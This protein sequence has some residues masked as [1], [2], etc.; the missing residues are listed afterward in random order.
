MLLAVGLL[1]AGVGTALFLRNS[2]IDGVDTQ[3]DSLARTDAASPLL[4]LSSDEGRL[5]AEPIDNAPS[6]DYFVAVYEPDEGQLLETAGGRGGPAPAFPEIYPLDHAL[7]QELQIKTIPSED[8]TTEFRATVTVQ[9]LG[10]TGVFYTQMVAVPLATVNRTIASYI[11]IYSILAILILV[12]GAVAT[13]Y[14]VTLTFRSLG[15]V[16]STA[17]AIAAGDF[18]LRMTDIEP[19][20]TE[21]GRLKTAINAMLDRVDAALS[22]RDATVRQMRRFIG[23][24]S[25]EL[26]TPLVTVRGYA[27]LYRMGAVRGEEDISQ[28][29]DRIEKEAIRMGLLVED[30]LALARLDERRDVVIGP[31]DLRPVARDAALDVRAAAPLRPVAVLDSTL[32]EPPLPPEGEASVSPDA[33]RRTTGAS[34]ISRAGA[35]LSLLRRR[36]KP[37][38]AAGSARDV[39]SPLLPEP[40]EPPTR[41]VLAPV[42]LGDENRIR[43]VVTNLL[44]NARRYSSEDSPIE[45]RVGVDARD[46][47]GWIEV[48]DHGEGVP[49]QIKDKIFQRFWRADTSRTRETGGSGL[50]L[51]IVASIVE[52]L[53]G[54]VGVVDT[55]GGGATFRVA[56]PL[57]DVRDAAEHLEIPTQPLPRLADATE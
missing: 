34:T 22:Q 40:E 29:M 30:L 3:V 2:L 24:A 14:L 26:R 51:S 39:P 54:S 27:E 17:D 8:G 7:P 45:L 16:E 57:A 36:P 56:F 21:V 47:M 49:D 20:T 15:Q 23:D 53:H 35:T 18:S 11:G 50:G 48:I 5:E 44:G 13:R 37:L 31:V 19:T 12:G 41:E 1:A 42:V 46:R 10:N 32:D 33:K 6:V 4:N 9:E 28:S 52:A 38:P 25:H 43:Q 55:P